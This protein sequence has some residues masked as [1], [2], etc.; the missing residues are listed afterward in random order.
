MTNFRVTLEQGGQK[1]ETLKDILPENSDRLDILFIAKTPA[2]KSVSAGHYFQGK[3]GQMFWNRL[4]DYGIIK[5]KQGTFEDENLLDNKFGLT[6]IVKK[7]RGFGDEPSEQ[8]YRE[9][10]KR[11]LDLIKKH[12]P[13]VTVFVY[14]RVLDNI[15]K[16]GHGLNKK[17]I[18]GFNPD[19]KKYFDSEVFVFPMPGTP[20]TTDNAVK[21]MNELKRMREQ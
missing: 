3:Q 11:I 5:L 7:P 6:D 14:K 2:T 17:S 4:K 8:E 16:W 15:L 1:F 21:A 12:Q 9:G 10:L 20:C 19:L 13:N 18:Y